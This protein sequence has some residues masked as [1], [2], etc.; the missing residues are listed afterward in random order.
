[1]SVEDRTGTVQAIARGALA[2]ALAGAAAGSAVSVAGIVRSRAGSRFGDVELEIESVELVPGSRGA[3]AR[4]ERFLT[5]AVQNAFES[6][7][8]D[9]LMRHGFLELHTPKLTA[10][11][12]ESGAEVFTVPY[13]GQAACLAQSPQFAMQLAMADGYDRV[14]EIGPVFRAEAAITNRHATEF[15]CIDVELAWIASH[16]DLMDVE[17]ALLREA[18]GA[19]RSAY[20]AAIERSFNVTVEVPE[21]PIP[22]VPYAEACALTGCGDGPRLTHA[23]EQALC[24]RMRA[25]T[26]HGFVFVTDFPSAARPFYTMREHGDP[27]A[28]GTSRSFDLL[29]RGI[30]VTSGCQR[31]HR[32]PRLRAQIVEKLGEAGL[33]GYLESHFLPLF[34]NGC[35]PH[36][37]FGIGLNRL[38]MALLARPSIRDTSFAY[39]DAEHLVP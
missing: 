25:H 34:E 23:G 4:P 12:S 29:W 9:A 35:P 2:E 19:V 17:E 13:F 6:A 39:R 22:R 31:E 33:A 36:G 3:R 16:A 14:F 27:S 30:E 11:G 28:A 37:G 32:A 18:L 38:L 7:L 8:R 24:K 1:M 10:G 21:T 5:F 15:T 26:G 20:G